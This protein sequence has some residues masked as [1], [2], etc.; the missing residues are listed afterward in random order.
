LGIATTSYLTAW[1]PK[2][3]YEFLEHCHALGAAGIQAG[4]HG[5][6]AGE[7]T[8]RADLNKLRSRAEQ[9]GMYIEAMVALP[10]GSDT[11]AFEQSLKDARQVG[12]IAL[13]SACLGSRRYETFFSAA[14]WQQ[15]VAESY[16]SIEAALPL[17]EKYKIP[18]GLENHKDW[19]ADEMVALQKKYGGEYFGVC[20]DFGNNL[21]LL[22]DPMDLI[23]KL[24]PYTINTHL[25]NMAVEPAPDGF[26]LSEVLLGDGYL[27]LNRVVSM[28]KAARPQT[29]FMLEM[30]TRDPL[31]VPCLTDK[32]WAAFPDRNGV[33]LARTLRFVDSH[34]SPKPLPRISKL[35]HAEQLRI[36]DQ[37][38]AACLDYANKHLSL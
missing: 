36:E 25:K 19:T 4:V 8:G 18:L 5:D 23:E 32:Y 27:D 37:N 10:R 7:A 17:L 38:V 2:D 15:H 31:V 24:A 20:L 3:T 30:I 16:R 33:Y 12:A 14:A 22:D 26:L 6:I 11:G 21:S 28:I 1:R 9:L 34:K 29:R 13:R 35:S